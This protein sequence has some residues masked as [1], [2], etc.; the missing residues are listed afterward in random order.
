MPL[1]IHSANKLE[2]P[3]HCECSV[4]IDSGVTDRTT[5]RY[6]NVAVVRTE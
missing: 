4:V 1:D 3:D 5:E 6:C 2:I